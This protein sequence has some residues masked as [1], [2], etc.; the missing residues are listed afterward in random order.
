MRLAN[1]VAM[2]KQAHRSKKHLEGLE[3][4]RTEKCHLCYPA[5]RAQVARNSQ[6]LCALRRSGR[7]PLANFEIPRCLPSLRLR[8]DLC[9]HAFLQHFSAPN[10][11]L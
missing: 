6:T 3:T 11:S 8:R 2:R 4:D 1:E 7:T 9:F 10:V 5:R